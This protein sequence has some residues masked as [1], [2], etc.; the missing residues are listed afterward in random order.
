VK[1]AEFEQHGGAVT[2]PSHPAA[3]DPLH[4]D[5]HR[6]DPSHT[7]ENV[8]SVYAS[9][10]RRPVVWTDTSGGFW[11][12]SRYEDIKWAEMRPGVFSSADGVLFPW[13][14]TTGAIAALEQ[15]GREHSFMRSL[16]ARWLSPRR[17]AAYES[18]VADVTAIYVKAFVASGGGDFV[19]AVAE[20]L[21]LTI[22]CQMLG[23]AGELTDVH[24]LNCAIRDGDPSGRDEL[25]SFI[26]DQVQQRKGRP[27][28]DFLSEALAA[29]MDG[30]TLSVAELA[31]WTVGGV[32]AGH[33]T[34][35]ATGSSLIYELAK[36]PDLQD[37]LRAEPLLLRSAVD[38]AVRLHPP[39]QGFFRT[40][41]EAVA[42]H[43][44]TMSAGDR[45]LLLFA[46]GNR[47]ER[48]FPEPS[49]FLLDR[50]S[51]A[52]LGFGWGPHRCVGATLAHLELITLTRQM[53]EHRFSL[54][55]QDEWGPPDVGLR[56]LPVAVS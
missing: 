37:R 24:R 36:S 50:R 47:D 9:L 25:V 21:P 16:Y 26:T 45:V 7:V 22:I 42:L 10:R 14:R 33:E 43:G 40:A 27:R 51:P 28:D 48:R 54:S 11:I 13:P 49:A 30:R 38:E 32:I 34:T 18:L 53:L 31:N 17:L 46:S 39:T 41:E 19:R 8:P 52:H 55:G 23:L 56:S 12:L 6:F 29:E 3:S 15:D 5:Y 35:L 4:V 20:A 44:V 2:P 1:H